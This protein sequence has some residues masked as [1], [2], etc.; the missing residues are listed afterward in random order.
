[1][2]LVSKRKHR[3]TREIAIRQQIIVVHMS[4]KK[5][6]DVEGNNIYF[7]GA[8]VWHSIRVPVTVDLAYCI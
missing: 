3:T 4:K 6:K 2:R 7:Y 1:M 5:K 8:K